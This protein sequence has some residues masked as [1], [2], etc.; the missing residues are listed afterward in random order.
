MQTALDSI[1]DKL[2]QGQ[3]LAHDDA[4]ALWETHDLIR[5]GMLADEARRRRHGTA[6]TF[7]RVADLEAAA[8]GAATVP[9]AAGELRLLGTAAALEA[10]LPR[11]TA[12]AAAHPQT[13]MTAGR[14]E[15]LVEDAGAGL[16][17]LLRALRQAG[18]AAV[19]SAAVDRVEDLAGAVRMARDAGLQVARFVVSQTPGEGPWALLARVAGL[20]RAT[21]AVRAFAPWPREQDPAR[22]TTGYADVKIV[23][24]ARLVLDEVPSIQVDWSLHG[25]K[26]AQVSLLFGADDIDAV[27]PWD[28]ATAGQRRAPLA[29]LLGNIRAASLTAVERDGRFDERPGAHG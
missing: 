20:Q 1:G 10:A 28:D 8:L 19:S 7:V 14:L 9:P 27:S 24:L 6:T 21:G 13:V 29:E 26:L 17:G 2:A 22:P 23:A 3:A 15:E 11:M 25:P 18:I 4:A 16:A 5:L 12:F